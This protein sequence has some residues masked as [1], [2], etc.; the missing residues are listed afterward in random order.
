MYAKPGSRLLLDRRALLCDF[1]LNGAV[2]QL[3]LV[4]VGGEEEKA[5]GGQRGSSAVVELNRYAIKRSRGHIKGG[6]RSGR[7]HAPARQNKADVFVF[8]V[9]FSYPHVFMGSCVCL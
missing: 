3:V 6:A 2:L 8:F 4:C 1:S 7:C 5:R 9:F